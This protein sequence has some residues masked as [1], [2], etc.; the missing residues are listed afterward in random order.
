MSLESEDVIALSLCIDLY[1]VSILEVCGAR[2]GLCDTYRTPTL[3]WNFFLVFGKSL[4]RLTTKQLAGDTMRANLVL[5][6]DSRSLG[7][8]DSI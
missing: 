4:I 7:T 8:S 2:L 5:G 3:R 6:F 1:G